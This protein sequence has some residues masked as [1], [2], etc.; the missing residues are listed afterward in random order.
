DKMTKAL[1]DAS[2]RLGAEIVLRSPVSK[3]ERTAGKVSVWCRNGPAG[4][5]KFEADRVVCTI[6]YSVL[7]NIP[8]TPAFELE[9]QRAINELGYTRVTKVFMQAKFVEWD[10]R[11]LGSSIWTDTPIERIFSTTGKTGDQRA[12]FTVW[13]EGDGSRKLQNMNAAKRISYAVSKFEKVLPFMRGAVEKSDTLSWSQE[14]FSKG[15]YAHFEVGQ[16]NSLSSVTAKSD[17]RIHFAGEHTAVSMPGMEG[18]LESAERVVS[19]IT[20]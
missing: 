11:S 20:R 14:P 18:A 15:A 6:P 17:G 8:V 19:E 9:K 3:I 7:R 10:K 16:F 13:T 2:R 1:A 4:L 5:K 12:L